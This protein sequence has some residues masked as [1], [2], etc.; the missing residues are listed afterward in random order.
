MDHCESNSSKN[1]SETPT[2]TSP[3]VS[4]ARRSGN[5]THPLLALRFLVAGEGAAD[6][7]NVDVV[8]AIMDNVIDITTRIDLVEPTD[9]ASPQEKLSA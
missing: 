3:N 7:Q 6:D 9:A 2:L 5:N 4:R 8:D 1:K